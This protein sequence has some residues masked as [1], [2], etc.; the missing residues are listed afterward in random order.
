MALVSRKE[1]KP[2][3]TAAIR[4]LLTL[5]ATPLCR[6]VSVVILIAPVGEARGLPERH[7]RNH[8]SEATRHHPPRIIG[9][10]RASSEASSYGHPVRSWSLPGCGFMQRA[11]TGTRGRTRTSCIAC[12]VDQC[13]F[14]GA[15]NGT[16][17]VRGLIARIRSDF[18]S[19]SSANT[20]HVDG[21]AVTYSGRC[22]TT[23]AFHH[24]LGVEAKPA[25]M[26]ATNTSYTRNSL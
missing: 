19:P 12:S 21:P 5:V 17:E 6:C 3:A 10:Q 18:P 1:R 20:H 8:D 26:S 13:G 22:L 25:D 4:P 7:W 15:R 14:T 24:R 16:R 11:R 9:R 23:L 2:I